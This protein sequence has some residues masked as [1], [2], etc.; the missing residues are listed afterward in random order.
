MLMVCDGK[1]PS[2]SCS[3]DV[4]D[5]WLWVDGCEMLCPSVESGGML[6]SDCNGKLL[7]LSSNNSVKC[8]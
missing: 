5:V 2:P 1:L 8:V 6:F 3:G 4:V 7:L